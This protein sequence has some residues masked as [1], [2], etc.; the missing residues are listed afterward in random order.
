MKHK[1]IVSLA[2]QL[3]T[4][5]SSEALFY[6]LHTNKFKFDLLTLDPPYHVFEIPK[7]SGGFR[8]IE[9][10]DDEL[11]DIQANLKVYLQALYHCYRTDAAFGFISKAD[12]E[13]ERKGIYENALAH[14]ND[15]YLLNTDL[16][17]FFHFIGWQQIHDSLLMAP[18][19][20]HQDI[21][22]EIC[23][24][25][26]FHGRLPMGAPTSPALSNIAVY[27]LDNEISLY[28]RQE[29]ITYTRYVDDMSFSARVPVSDRQV[30]QIRSIIVSH[31]YE[32]NMDKV[33]RFN[34]GDMKIITGL[35]IEN[36]K[37]KVPDN[38]WQEVQN[39]IAELRGWVVTQTKLHPNKSLDNMVQ[40]PLQKISGALQFIEDIEG[41][42]D[43]RLG[44]MRQQLN[45]AIIPP[46]DYES[47]NWLEIGYEIF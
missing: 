2:R 11:Q 35:E 39:Q 40:L 25:C 9:D 28:C 12:D 3:Q 6:L 32:L 29:K 26:T 47:R 41:P 42:K 22:P 33:K 16:T 30:D 13:S 24:L 15:D 23:N 44:N 37:V 43:K 7:R 21:L 20:V 10:P 34:P 19:H 31:G 4:V 18:F 27:T 38:F 46:E 45:D 14:V 8:V 17:D 36:G 5:E 1:T